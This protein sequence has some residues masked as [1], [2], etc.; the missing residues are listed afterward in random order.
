MFD[1]TCLD[2]Y[3]DTIQTLTQWDINQSIYIEDSG[4]TN[5]PQFHFC[6]KN[7]EKALVVQSTLN[8][9]GVLVVPV[10]NLL[11]TEPY[12]ISMYVYLFEDNA[13]KT[14]ETI[15]IPVRQ[16]PQPD[17]FEFED[18]TEIINLSNI[19][20]EMKA[21]NDQI[22]IAELDR[23]QKETIRI[24]NEDARIAAETARATAETE[25]ANAE[26]ERDSAEDERSAAEATRLTNEST[27]MTA[28]TAR[29]NAENSR[30]TNETERVDAEA[31]RV[32]AETTRIS[33]ETARIDAEDIR[34]DNETTRTTNETNRQFAEANRVDAEAIR[35]ENEITRQT[36]EADR[37]TNTATAIENANKATDRAN[38]AAEGCE[39]I[40][41]GTGLVSSTEKGVANGVATLDG[42]GKIPTNQLPDELNDISDLTSHVVNT[43]N[44]HEVTKTQV[45]LSNVPN[46]TTND[47]T[48]TYT[49]ATS[50]TALTSGEKLSVAF[51]KI[52][53]AVSS[54]ISH[55]ADATIH[56]T[57]SNKI[58]LD[59][60]TASYT[61]EEKSKLKGV[62]EGANKYSH[63]TTSGNKHIPSGG[64]S[65][66]ILR[67]SA[68]GTAAWGSDSN[69]DTKN[70]AGSTDSSKKLFLIGAESQAANP[71]TYSHDTCYVGTDGYLYSNGVKV[72]MA[73]S[74]SASK[75]MYGT[76]GGQVKANATAMA[77][78]TNAQ[79]R[80][81]VV[82]TS[83][84]EGGTASE[85]NGTIVFTKG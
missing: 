11:I 18:N 45:G 75:I 77:T 64:S 55:I 74:H 17:D 68:D 37:Q 47:Q 58:V 40:I 85:S 43:S 67:W 19:A 1:I 54:L 26:I 79:V 30:Q 33:N 35:V 23:V 78:L 29:D 57:H 41:A 12:T 50:T 72:D 46:V 7:T 42:D 51:G 13:G 24:H 66:Q 20:A 73:H 84:T 9:D 80:D 8:S 21:L 65:G 5:P 3:G 22:A 39:G 63:P 10:P 49:E 25:R 48:P 56:H 38:R 70:T 69:T 59:Y 62:A 28:E 32:T 34:E 82:K 83:V 60:T 53:K 2:R 76:L 6:N 4:F 44:P 36:Q 14:I 31:D 81:I 71:Q 61:T 16:R 15:Q 52:A 27:R